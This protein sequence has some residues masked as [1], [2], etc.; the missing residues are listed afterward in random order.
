[1]GTRKSRFEKTL[2]G[3]TVARVRMMVIDRYGN[4]SLRPSKVL[5]KGNYSCLSWS[6]KPKLSD[7]LIL[8]S[9]TN[10]TSLVIYVNQEIAWKCFIAR[11]QKALWARWFKYSSFF[12]SETVDRYKAVRLKNYMNDLNGQLKCPQYW[13]RLYYSS[14]KHWNAKE[15]NINYSIWF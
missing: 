5:Q 6:R 7:L 14:V 9:G 12:G 2:W 4:L 1:M 3:D 11:N 10:C 8:C 13:L 15:N